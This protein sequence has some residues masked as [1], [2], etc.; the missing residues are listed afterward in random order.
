MRFPV[1]PNSVSLGLGYFERYLAFPAAK[2]MYAVA[3][4]CRNNF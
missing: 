1:G 2:F 4:M 3:F